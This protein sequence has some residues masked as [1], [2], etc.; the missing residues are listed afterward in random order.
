M[1]SIVYFALFII[2]IVS[3]L[4]CKEDFTISPTQ[5][6]TV[7]G[8]VLN[9]TS[10]VPVAN[11]LV[12]LSPNNRIVRTDASGVFRFDSVLAGAYTLQAER[13]GFTTQIA[14]VTVT[15]DVAPPSITLILAQVQVP[16]TPPTVPTLVAPTSATTIQ[17]T[18]VTLKWKATDP[19]NDTLRYEVLLYK[20]SLTTPVQSYTGL[21]IDTLALSNLEYNTTYFWKVSASDQVNVVNGPVWSFT[22]PAF[23]NYSYLFARPLNGQFQIFGSNATGEAVQITRNGSNWRPVTSPNKQQVAFIS[24][25]NTNLHLFI[26]NLDGSNTRQITSVP[27]GGLNQLD[28]SFCWSPDGTQ[29]LYPSNNRLFAINIDGTGLRAVAQAPSGRAFAGCDWTPQGNRIAARTTGDSV[30]DNEISTFNTDGSDSKT[31][32]IRRDRRVG[33]PVYSVTGRQLVFSA[34]SSGFMNEQGRQL[35]ARLYLF[36]LAT[37]AVF[38]LS[39]FPTPSSQTSP[40]LNNKVA[41]TNDLDPR[42]SPNGAQL[43]FTNTDNSETGTPAVYAINLSTIAQDN[44]NRRL[45][46]SSARMPDWRQP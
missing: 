2:G 12:T 37:Y 35:D 23:P 33:N 38:D 29:L 1:K 39:V 18:S 27:V 32:Y 20:S 44:R 30:Y 8:R 34:D 17:S 26:M 43:I 25:R 11:A 46:F 7:Q 4:S 19:N 22:T 3:L 36:D 9:N 42:F 45:L 6:A 15:G 24:N 40:N 21:T 14:S 13:A 10:L 28:L 31:V 16:N 5:Y 41:G